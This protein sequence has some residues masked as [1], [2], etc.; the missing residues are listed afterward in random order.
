LYTTHGY[1]DGDGVGGVLY[2]GGSVYV[3]IAMKGTLS[4][5]DV[6]LRAGC[7]HQMGRG[8]VLVGAL[9]K[10]IPNGEPR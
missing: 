6:E 1:A 4:V 8:L 10:G 5:G 3:K 7:S 2:G 9:C